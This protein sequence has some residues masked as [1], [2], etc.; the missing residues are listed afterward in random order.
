MA[1]HVCRAETR[2]RRVPGGPLPGPPVTYPLDPIAVALQVT[3]ALD[4]LGVAHTIGGSIASS[5]AGE[6]RSTIDVDIVAALE[7]AHV[8]E[9]V[10]LLSADFY[11][12]EQAI[13]RAVRS[14]GACPSGVG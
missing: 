12:D 10:G 4:T 2:E 1:R 14:N 11:L 8:P 9:F 3:T 7:E 13:G 6:P 5:L